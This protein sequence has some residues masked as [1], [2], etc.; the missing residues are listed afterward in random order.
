MKSS[1][2]VKLGLITTLALAG[3]DNQN[4][5]NKC[6]DKTPEECQQLQQAYTG[7]HGHKRGRISNWQLCTLY[8]ACY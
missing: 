2:I 3:C 5:H 1:R 8:S 7:S 6:K 4:D